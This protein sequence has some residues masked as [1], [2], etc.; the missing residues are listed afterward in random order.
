MSELE[1]CPFEAAT[2]KWESKDEWMFADRR[3]ERMF[4][5]REGARTSTL[6]VEVQRAVE[7]VIKVKAQH[8]SFS[9]DLPL[10]S[11]DTLDELWK[12]LAAINEQ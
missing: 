5:F 7:A 8:D 3:A 9:H 11:L 1:S 6:P 4:F 12:A 10:S 2:E